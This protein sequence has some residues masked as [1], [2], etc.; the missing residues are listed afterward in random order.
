MT[1]RV[2]QRWESQGVDVIPAEKG[3]SLFFDLLRSPGPQVAVLPIRWPEFLRHAGAPEVPPLFSGW[4][5]QAPV[6]R[7]RQDSDLTARL[8]QAVPRERR[9]ILVDFVTAEAARLLGPQAARA[10]EPSRPLQEMGLDSL[11]A[12]EL[13]NVV[14]QAVGRALPAAVLFNYP[15]ADALAGHLLRDV[16]RLEE[17]QPAPPP[18]QARAGEDLLD[19]LEQMS[20]DEVERLLGERANS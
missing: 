17:E 18:T 5:G 3:V 4:S 2:D 6:P 14:G 8:A 11:M 9:G 12:V 1:A 15:S 7:E 10:L 16:L 19:Q 20:D 13:R